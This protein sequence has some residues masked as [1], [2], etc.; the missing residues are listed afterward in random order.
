MKAN[1]TV[2]GTVIRPVRVAP[3]DSIPEP[4]TGDSLFTGKAKKIINNTVIGVVLIFRELD[5]DVFEGG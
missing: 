1:K 5:F 2:N 3:R 4:S